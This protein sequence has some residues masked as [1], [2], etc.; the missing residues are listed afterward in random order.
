MKDDEKLVEKEEHEEKPDE[1]ETKPAEEETK[2]AEE[3]TKPAEEET[4][5]AEE[6][7]EET[8][9]EEEGV[10]EEQEAKEMEAT[11]KD[12]EAKEVE[13]TEEAEETM[14]SAEKQ[15][16][17]VEE[18][19]EDNEKESAA[20]AVDDAMEEKEESSEDKPEEPEKSKEEEE[21]MAASS[22]EEVVDYKPIQQALPDHKERAPHQPSSQSSCEII[23]LIGLPAAGKTTW[24]QKFCRDQKEKVYEILGPE[25]VLDKMGLGR[26]GWKENYE[27]L[28]KQA[29]EIVNNMLVL[30]SESMKNFIIDQVTV[31]CMW[32]DSSMYP[33]RAMCIDQLK[34]GKLDTLKGFAVKL[35]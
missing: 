26:V 14:E 7:N 8:A 6:V 12:E 34:S 27:T 13:V 32:Y 15:E 19:I 24:A 16:P 21:K 30:A 3:E 4:K 33:Y 29:N 2:P 23:F 1:E 9:M 5:P 17:A 25:M 28:L 11:E 31:M 20:E 35:L 18:K 10:K 22:E